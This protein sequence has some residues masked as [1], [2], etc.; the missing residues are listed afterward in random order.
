[1]ELFLW[2]L[3][4]ATLGGTFIK[5]RQFQRVHKYH[6]ESDG[7]LVERDQQPTKQGIIYGI[8]PFRAQPLLSII[9]ETQGT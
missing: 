9:N 4:P 1:M 7:W 2:K 3:W 6:F 8:C 5:P